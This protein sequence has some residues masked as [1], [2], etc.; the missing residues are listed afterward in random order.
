[1]ETIKERKEKSASM[2]ED[3]ALLLVDLYIRDEKMYNG[4]L[5]GGSKNGKSPRQ[6]CIAKWLTE[7]SAIGCDKTVDYLTNRIRGDLQLVRSVLSEEKTERG[8]TGGGL[9]KKSKKLDLARTKLYEH[10]RG[11]HLVEGLSCGFE[12]GAGETSTV[13]KE[14]HQID[15]LSESSNMLTSNSGSD[16]IV[17]EDDVDNPCSSSNN[18]S[19]KTKTT[20][21]KDFAKS[22]RKRPSTKN[23][24][25]ICDL[26]RSLLTAEIQ[27]AEKKARN[28]DKEYEQMKKKDDILAIEKETAILKRTLLMQKLQ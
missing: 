25:E 2:P 3:A 18:A 13:A 4:R 15:I 26:R 11:S 20:S 28:L 7:L 1:M 9:P 10:L 23:T 16:E 14:T 5:I 27:L 17:I 12:S 24:D 19:E 6:L 22:S 21:F 8:K